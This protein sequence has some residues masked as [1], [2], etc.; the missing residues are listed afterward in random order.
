MSNAKDDDQRRRHGRAAR[1]L[2]LDALSRELDTDDH[3]ELELFDA[4]YVEGK[5]A[6]YD[7]LKTATGC[8]G[9]IAA[10]KLAKL[11]QG[12]MRL[13]GM[14]PDGCFLLDAART[15]VAMRADQE[16][17]AEEWAPDAHPLLWRKDGWPT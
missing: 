17:P 12:L 14:E 9:P 11:G 4:G 8:D 1:A 16:C 2:G 13:R 10:Y 6:I 3:R 5:K 7:R 15:L